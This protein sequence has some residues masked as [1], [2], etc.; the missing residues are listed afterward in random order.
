MSMSAFDH[1]EGIYGST[2][3]PLVGEPSGDVSGELLRAL[4]L[5]SSAIGGTEIGG[6]DGVALLIRPL[7]RGCCTDHCVADGFG[8]G[9]RRRG[10]L[11]GR[12][13]A[14]M[15]LI[16]GVGVLPVV[17]GLAGA[18]AEVAGLITK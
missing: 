18:G 4:K 15:L 14:R 10:E 8:F 12:A 11:A 9:S 1:N 3:K 6:T 17:S 13:F 2:T 16:N 7:R 5:F